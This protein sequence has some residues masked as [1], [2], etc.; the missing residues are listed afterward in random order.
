MRNY[1]FSAPI[2]NSAPNRAT[3][4]A[5]MHT[6]S[7]QFLASIAALA[8]LAGTG[9]SSPKTA[10][11]QAAAKAPVRAAYIPTVS[12]LPVLVAKDKGFFADAGLDVTL[13]PTQNV[14]MLPG[15]LGKQL[16]IAPSTPPDLIKSAMSGLDI[17]TIAGMTI[18]DGATRGAELIVRKDSGINSLK[19]LKGKV[20]ASPTLGAIIHV[21]LL[22]W[23]KQNGMDPDSIRAVEV[24]FPNMGDQLKAGS[25]DAIEAIQPFVGPLLA[26][27]NVTIGDPIL[28]IA[29]PSLYTNWI[30]QGAWARANP[31][32]VAAWNASLKKSLAFIAENPAEA[33]TIMAKYTGLP[34]AVVQHIPFPHYDVAVQ[35][36]Q[37]EVWIKVLRD[38]D[39]ISG[40]VDAAKLIVSAP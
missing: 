29:D 38:L 36:A 12:W 7:R 39:Q 21:A 1:N 24:P 32:V 26:A 11:A 33:R 14:S 25:V 22:H 23:L 35:P 5:F 8:L 4:G 18:D 27:G 34:E 10:A 2:R 17:V 40:T 30:A 28:A 15:T 37:I 13:T 16:D 9:L 31:S 3:K 20:V 19:D 6:I